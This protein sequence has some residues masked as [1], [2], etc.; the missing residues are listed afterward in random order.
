MNPSLIIG[1]MSSYVTS[2][3]W[4]W[5]DAAFDADTD[6]IHVDVY[7]ERSNPTNV[8]IALD[9]MAMG[10]PTYVDYTV[11]DTNLVTGDFSQYTLPSSSRLTLTVFG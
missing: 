5:V 11:E 4:T 8:D 2:D 6:T 3:H 1:W 7:D 10:L 9:L